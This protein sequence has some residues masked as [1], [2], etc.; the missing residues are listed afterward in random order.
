MYAYTHGP[1]LRVDLHSLDI[2]V[3]GFEKTIYEVT[4][5]MDSVEVCAV[6]YSPNVSCPVLFPF[7]VSIDAGNEYTAKKRWLF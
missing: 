3:V 2:A 4:E 5:Y 7:V 1:V 6:V